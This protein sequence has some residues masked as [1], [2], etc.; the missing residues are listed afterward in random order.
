[1]SQTPAEKMANRNALAR[2]K[3]NTETARKGSGE[4]RYA[5]QD[6]DRAIAESFRV[7][8]G[9]DFDATARPETDPIY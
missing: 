3:A 6:I 8:D 4:V 7:N 5:N 9:P 2:S 1:M